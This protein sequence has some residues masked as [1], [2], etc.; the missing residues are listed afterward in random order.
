[1][2]AVLDFEQVLDELAELSCFPESALEVRRVVDRPGSSLRDIERVVQKD[3]LLASRLLKLANAPFYGRSREVVRVRDALATLGVASVRNLALSLALSETAT[4]VCG[5]GAV[6]VLQHGLL[7]AVLG[8]RLHPRGSAAADVAFTAG[9][10]H[11]VGLLGMMALVGPEVGEHH[12]HDDGVDVI[13]R[14]EA[15]YG[16]SH[17]RL[18]AAL[19]SGWNL[20]DD[21][22]KA[23]SDHHGYALE[24]GPAAALRLCSELAR[25]IQAGNDADDVIVER[26]FGS[27]PNQALQLTDALLGAAVEHARGTAV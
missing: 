17:V 10:V 15:A 16:F 5:A 23:V 6:P 2:T 27:G 7:T 19:L 25:D 18:G 14:E 8:E 9:I 21:V 3:A 26:A 22:V 11:H 13:I 20:P 1:M 4:T 12:R 24:P